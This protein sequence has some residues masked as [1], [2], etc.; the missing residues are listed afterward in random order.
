MTLSEVQAEIEAD[1]SRVISQLPAADLS[2]SAAAALILE[3][4]EQIAAQD[5]LRRRLDD[6]LRCQKLIADRPAKMRSYI[7][8][9]RGNVERS[10]AAQSGNFTGEVGH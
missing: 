5:D 7:D 2:A 1:I 9:A 3:I 10:K 6:M 4:E 8:G